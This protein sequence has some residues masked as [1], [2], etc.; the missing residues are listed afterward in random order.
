LYYTAHSHTQVLFIQHL[1]ATRVSPD[2]PLPGDTSAVI[3]MMIM[4][5]CNNLKSTDDIMWNMNM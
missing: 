5:R 3:V 4:L 1:C 2:P